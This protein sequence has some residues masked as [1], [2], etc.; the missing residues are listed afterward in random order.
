MYIIKPNESIQ[1]NAYSVM[2]E[3]SSISY[4]QDQ[5][6]KLHLP[7]NELFLKDSLWAI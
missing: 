2:N 7:T 5:V 4:S 3:T 1:E 6:S